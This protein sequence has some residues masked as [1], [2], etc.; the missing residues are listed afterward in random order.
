MFCGKVTADIFFKNHY[1]L[2]TYLAYSRW[3]VLGKK[4]L[5][6]LTGC[7]WPAGCS[8]PMRELVPLTTKQLG[9]WSNLCPIS[10]WPSSLHLIPWPCM[11]GIKRPTTGRGRC[12]SLSWVATAPWLCKKKPFLRARLSFKPCGK[13]SSSNSIQQCVYSPHPLG[14]DLNP[15]LMLRSESCPL[16]GVLSPALRLFSKSYWLCSFM[17]WRTGPSNQS[18][19][20]LQVTQHKETCVYTFVCF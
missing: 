7:I 2:L 17:G 6:S 18:S 3:S 20:L 16:R 13:G 10:R 14:W 19:R 11:S 1:R 15:A 4:I 5:K 8:L 9:R 12:P